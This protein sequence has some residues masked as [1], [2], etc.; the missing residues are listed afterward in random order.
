MSNL[1]ILNPILPCDLEHPVITRFNNI[2]DQQNTQLAI[3]DSEGSISYYDLQNLVASYA[4]VITSKTEPNYC[5]AI[6][7][8]TGRHFVAAML[9]ALSVGCP[10]VPLDV[11]FPTLRLQ[12]ILKA[13]GARQI[14]V[15]DLSLFEQLMHD[16][17]Q[18]ELISVITPDNLIPGKEMAVRAVADSVAYILYTSGSTG[19]PKGVWQTQRGLLHDI[20]QYGEIAR[21]TPKDRLSLLYSPSVNGALRDIYG[22]LLNGA[23]L[24]MSNIR[25]DGLTKTV[26]NLNKQKITILHAMPPVLRSLIRAA[27]NQL[28]C[29]HARLAYIAGDKLFSQD[30]KVLRAALPSDCTIY[31]GIGST[32]CAT[33]YRHWI[34]PSDWPL[35]ESTLPVGYS[36][37]DREVRLI[38][39]NGN[40]TPIG[41]IGQI[42]VCSRFIAQGY[43]RNESLTKSVFTSDVSRSDIRCFRTGDLGRI[44]QD[45]LLEFMGRADRQLKIRG[46]RVEPAEIESV[47]RSHP[48]VDEVAIIADETAS[49]IL[50]TAYVQ[51]SAEQTTLVSD[52]KAMVSKHLPSYLRPH[53]IFVLKALP[54][55]ANFKIDINA[56]RE[57]HKQQKPADKLGAS[58]ELEELIALWEAVLQRTINP[59]QSF[60]DAGGDSLNLLELELALEKKY[61]QLPDNII[62]PEV[63]PRMMMDQLMQRI[64]S[65]SVP[66][67]QLIHSEFDNQCIKILS[68]LQRLMNQSK[69][70]L[71]ND[72]G[73]IRIHNQ[74]GEKPPLFW[75]FNSAAEFD[76]MAKELG[77]DQP[78]YGMRSFNQLVD[79]DRPDLTE[80][81]LWIAA[82]YTKTILKFTSFSSCA[83]GGNCQA[84][85]IALSI[86]SSLLLAGKAVNVL[87]LMEK[88][89]PIPYPGRVLLIF[90]ENSHSHNPFLNFANPESA[91]IKYYREVKSSIIPGS[92]GQYFRINNLPYLCNVIRSELAYSLTNTLKVLPQNAREVLLTYQLFQ[93]LSKQQD[94]ILLD[95]H[96]HNPTAYSWDAGENSHIMLSLYWVDSHN[97][98]RPHRQPDYTFR[99]PATI[100]PGSNLTVPIK[101]PLPLAKKSEFLLVGLCE[102]GIGWF[103]EIEGSETSIPISGFAF[104]SVPK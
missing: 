54:L 74:T 42:I 104:K 41:D 103:K 43:W 1:N 99:L 97:A 82:I 96:I 26:N 59:N 68:D 47:L 29:P 60:I 98:Q 44:R 87:L 57:L 36:I 52:L 72:E 56:L 4:N 48:C 13:S 16:H 65:L 3:I 101:V 62:T 55:L 88:V 81:E 31:T 11:N 94:E 78:L 50:L 22:S 24:C 21:I 5:V 28:L 27:Q 9:G 25:Q 12:Q 95:I 92:H 39:S 67:K 70:S 80:L 20:M 49:N 18:K 15:Q 37:A 32:E 83:I 58:A 30:I 63:S 90:G 40:D 35:S 8:P 19:V 7:L 69:G 6:L 85:R 46:Y 66:K 17:N 93:D 75:C 71:I 23:V 79:L 53:N 77:E 51:S 73:L 86:A 91:W 33:I 38:N 61:G 10:Y 45:G 84:A 34:I 89:P 2:C 102:E 76:S 100:I 14:I 64:E